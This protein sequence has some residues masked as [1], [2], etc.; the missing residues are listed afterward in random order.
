VRSDGI[1]QKLTAAEAFLLHMTRR[2]LGGDTAAAR[3]TLDAIETAPAQVN[4]EARRDIAE[5]LIQFRGT[6]PTSCVE[7][8]LRNLN[9]A[10]KLDAYRDTARVVL[11]PWLVELALSRLGSRQL[12]RES[13]EAVWRGTRTPWKVVWPKWWTFWGE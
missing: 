4:R 2:G 11:E 12:D 7:Q 9:M 13:Q 10:V 5:I 1:E 3:A 8:T 6:S